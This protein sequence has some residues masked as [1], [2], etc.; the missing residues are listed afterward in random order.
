MSGSDVQA[1]EY[2]L[3]PMLA[4]LGLPHRFA[5][6]QY[7]LNVRQSR[8]DGMA[9]MSRRRL[10]HSRIKILHNAYI[11]KT[12]DFLLTPYFL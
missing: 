4:L 11:Y 12:S 7:F 6:V 10:Y 9:M 2:E 8:Q 5:V 3:I 1:L